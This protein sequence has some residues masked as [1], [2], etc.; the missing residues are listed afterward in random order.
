MSIGGSMKAYKNLGLGLCVF[1]G[2]SLSSMILFGLENHPWDEQRL[3]DLI[4][5]PQ[6]KR[7][8]AKQFEGVPDITFDKSTVAYDQFRNDVIVVSVDFVH[9]PSGKHG[10]ASFAYR[11]LDLD[12]VLIHSSYFLW[13]TEVSGAINTSTT[14]N[15]AG[16]PYYVTGRTQVNPA[17]TLTI[18]PGT[19]V[20]FR[21]ITHDVVEFV[22]Y[23]T[24]NCQNA[25]FTSS[26]DFEDY[27]QEQV[28]W[29]S[30]DWN[31][32]EFLSTGTGTIEDCL[33]EYAHNGVNDNSAGG[34]TLTGNTVRKCSYGVNM[35]TTAG[36]SAV[37]IDNN[38]F[39]D[40]ENAIAC[41]GHTASTTISNNTMSCAVKWDGFA[42]IYLYMSSPV[43]SANSILD[44]YDYGVYCGYNSSPSITLNTIQ[45]TG[46]GIYSFSGSQPVVNNNNI[47]GSVYYGLYNSDT[48]VTIDAE[49]NWW[50]DAS[51]P[52][53]AT[54]NPGGLGDWVSNDVDFI[55]WLTSAVTGQILKVL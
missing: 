17:A 53:H 21:K 49:N 6:T 7:A 4:D 5:S 3:T 46:Y 31:G 36:G 15:P 41:S 26:C 8:L 11:F 33:I 23:G 38:D 9:N 52:Y 44:S 30:C 43:I 16:S 51:G 28:G 42:G 22:V 55:P 10:T 40:C 50:G 20:R 54:L 35:G 47:V 12:Y 25:T 27:D 45:N 48:M 18:E 2:M 32:F 37:T 34:L 14:W 13:G 19:V 24:L 29:D 1:L 39:V